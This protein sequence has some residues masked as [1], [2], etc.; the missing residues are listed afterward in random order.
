[1]CVAYIVDT[2]F[3]TLSRVIPCPKLSH[4]TLLAKIK[5][6]ALLAVYNVYVCRYLYHRY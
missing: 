3:D 1:M 2:A 5:F 4:F 6:T